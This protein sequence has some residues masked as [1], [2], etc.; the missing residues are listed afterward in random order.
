MDWLI[1]LQLHRSLKDQAYPYKCALETVLVAS[2][3]PKARIAN[4]QLGNSSSHVLSSDD[5][6]IVYGPD[7]VDPSCSRCGEQ[8]ETSLHTY[9][10]CPCNSDIDSEHIRNSNHLIDK[11]VLESIDEPCLWL[12]GVLPKTHTEHLINHSPPRL[13]LVITSSDPSVTIYPSG[14]YYGDASGGRDTKLPPMRRC[15]CAFYLPH[16]TQHRSLL[17]GF[18]LPGSIQTVARAELFVL[19]VLIEGCVE[20]ANIE[21]VTDNKTNNDLFHE[22]QIQFSSILHSLNLDLFRRIFK[23]IETKHLTV[24]VRWM[25]SHLAEKLA[26]NPDFHI[27]AGVSREDIQHNSV[28]DTEAGERADRFAVPLNTV[29]EYRKVIKQV[30]LIQN[31]LT[32]IL[33]NLPN[34]AHKDIAKPKVPPVTVSQLIQLSPHKVVARGNVLSCSACLA[35]VSSSSKV[36][37][38]WLQSSCTPV[39][40]QV[41]WRPQALD[42]MPTSL[43][44]VHFSHLKHM[45]QVVISGVHCK[46]CNRCGSVFGK[47][48]DKLKKQCTTPTDNGASNRKRL[49][50]GLLPYHLDP[51]RTQYKPPLQSISEHAPFVPPSHPSDTMEYSEV[52]DYLRKGNRAVAK[53]LPIIKPNSQPSEIKPVQLVSSTSLSKAIS[54]P[55]VRLPTTSHVSAHPNIGVLSAAV[56]VV[57]TVQSSSS[58]AFEITSAPVVASAASFSLPLASQMSEQVPS[59]QDQI[60]G[61]DATDK[62]KRRKLRP[63]SSFDANFLEAHGSLPEDALAISSAASF[64]LSPANV[65][66]EQAP[67]SHDNVSRADATDG[68]KRRKLRPMSSSDAN[69]YETHGSLPED[70]S[71]VLEATSSSSLNVMDPTSNSS[72]VNM[73][74]M[75]TGS[76]SSA[77]SISSTSVDSTGIFPTLTGNAVNIAKR[78]ISSSS[79][80]K[81]ARRRILPSGLSTSSGTSSD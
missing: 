56:N 71:V 78:T 81:V 51:T 10:Q 62:N 45:K 79:S 61:A 30:Y 59:S 23:A 14:V 53:L 33:I 44:G 22:A 32:T 13:T 29:I 16:T 39:D 40:A 58:S 27:P 17:V 42:I 12:R 26:K 48:L 77:H 1:S 21:F 20:N 46:W 37:K 2:C 52:G 18:N 35:Q 47:R 65:I 5:A 76:T 73:S 34:R 66:S 4:A 57:P 75:T 55:Q 72:S 11:A 50:A 70:T 43:V 24:S 63:M 6:I 67:T 25:P 19:V 31:R 54:F 74:I 8:F 49:N 68:S 69:F 60:S 3:W 41:L 9:W 80:G 15:G 7:S 38:S 64:S 28:V 36:L